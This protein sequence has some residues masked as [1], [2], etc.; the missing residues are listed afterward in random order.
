MRSG[1]IHHRWYRR[2]VALIVALL[3]W[4]SITVAS[5]QTNIINLVTK[6]NPWLKSNGTAMTDPGGDQQ[7]GQGQD[8]YIGNLTTCGLMQQVVQD[9]LVAGDAGKYIVF[10]FRMGKY[11]SNG[12][13]GNTEIGFKLNS[14]TDGPIN[15]VMKMTDKTGTQTLTFTTPGAGANNSPSTPSWGNYAGSITLS[16]NT[17]NYANATAV[18]GIVLNS[19]ANGGTPTDST[20]STS[21]VANSWVTFA[22]GYSQLQTAIRTYAVDPTSGTPT[23]PAFTSYTVSDNSMMSLIAFTSTQG[24]A[25][26]QDLFGTTRNTNSSATYSS[27]GV[28]TAWGRPDGTIPEPATFFQL[29]GL[30]MTGVAVRF[31]RTRKSRPQTS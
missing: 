25:I 28:G 29:G 17:Y 23:A 27:L 3:L 8:D 24:N 9:P 19:T 22:I 13:G 16:A 7:T 26:N 1:F 31:W 18:D 10:R 20:K 4:G 2:P 14:V 11:D 5:G 21:Y 30:L 15:L 6:W 12:F